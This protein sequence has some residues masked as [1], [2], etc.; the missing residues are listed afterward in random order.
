MRLHK[1]DLVNVAP[2]E[3]DQEFSA[4]SLGDSHSPQ[5]VGEARVAAD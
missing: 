1:R 4:G 2:L 3:L 5:Q